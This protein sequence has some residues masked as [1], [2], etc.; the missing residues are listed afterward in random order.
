MCNTLR[1][2]S[3]TYVGET[4][5]LKED[6][7]SGKE[8]TCKAGHVGLVPG[9]GRRPGGETGSP[10]QCACLGD[11][12]DRGAWRAAVFLPGRPHGQRGLAGRSVPA[13]ETPWTEGPGWPQCSCL[14]DPMD[15][16]AWR[17]AAHGVTTKQQQQEREITK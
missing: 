9:S 14:G 11:P 5:R 12:M 16:G 3:N 6:W 10:L 8:P 7:L 13:W 17:A 1:H 15:R 4:D 2:K